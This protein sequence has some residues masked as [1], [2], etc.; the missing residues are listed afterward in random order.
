MR[1]VMGTDSFPEISADLKRAEDSMYALGRY[2]DDIERLRKTPLPPHAQIAKPKVYL[3]WVEGT[4]YFKIGF[5][6]QPLRARLSEIQVGCPIHLHVAA[7]AF[8]SKSDEKTLH[9]QLK[10]YRVRG[11]WFDFYGESTAFRKL[12]S[13]FGINLPAEMR[14]PCLEN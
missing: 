8:G 14:I 2:A 5:S 1:G 13:V 6:S 9:G 10:Q 7:V 4:S 11:E 3:L 12:L